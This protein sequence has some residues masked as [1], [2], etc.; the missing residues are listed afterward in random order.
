MESPA[1]LNNACRLPNMTA[2]AL[3]KPVPLMVTIVP[4]EDGPEEG[5]TAMT[6]GRATGSIQ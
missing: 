1:A 2:V 6:A 4:P 5:E 3:E